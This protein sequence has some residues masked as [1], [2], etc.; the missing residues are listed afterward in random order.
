MPAS[1]TPYRKSVD[2]NFKRAA[3]ANVLFLLICILSFTAIGQSGHCHRHC[4]RRRWRA[5]Q[6]RIR[7]SAEF[8]DA[9]NRHCAVGQN[10]PLS[11]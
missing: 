3:V 11:H 1:H 8:K 10:W 2:R 9:Y 5:F 6:G 7:R 4:Y